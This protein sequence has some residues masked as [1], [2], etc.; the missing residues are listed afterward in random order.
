MTYQEAKTQIFYKR[1]IGGFVV[2]LMLFAILTSF[3]KYIHNM[4]F[5]TMLSSLT[6]FKNL[7]GFIST[8]YS[9]TNFFPLSWIWKVTPDLRPNDLTSMA[10]FISMGIVL[11]FGSNIIHSAN[12]LSRQFKK[13]LQR[14]EDEKNFNQLKKENGL[15]SMLEQKTIVI[16]SNESTS[17]MFHKLYLAPIIVGVILLLASNFLP[18]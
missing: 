1:F 18:K 8:I 13:H 6:I 4:T 9:K 10:G 14:I 16:D 17:S 15:P 12:Q 3:L 7:D 11:I 2:I 5:S